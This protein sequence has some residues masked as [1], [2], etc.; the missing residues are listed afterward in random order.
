MRPYYDHGGITIFHGDC[1]EIPAWL[2]ASVMVTDPPYGIAWSRGVNN[3]RNSAAHDGIA[4]DEDVSTRDSA[5]ALFGD[6]PA[7]VFGSFY[8]P[9]PPNLRHV[10][11]WHKPPDAGVVGS[12][13]GFRRDVE[14]IFL[15]GPWPAQAVQWSS[16]IRDASQSISEVARSAGH[17]HAKPIGLVRSLMIRL[18]SAPVRLCDPFMGSGTVLV[19]ARDLGHQAIGVDVEESN[20]ER[21]AKRLAQQTLFGIGREAARIG[22]PF[23]PGT[24]LLHDPANE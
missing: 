21:A 23:A 4:G 16:V 19:A 12:T 9:F 10:C 3:A 6:K 18:L 13:T 1:R 5:L 15:C 22:L 11:V 17:P 8:A 14:P 20:C 7:L 24:E 2:S